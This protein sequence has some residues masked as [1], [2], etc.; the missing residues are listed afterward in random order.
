MS[1]RMQLQTRL[2]LL[3]ALAILCCAALSTPASA[4]AKQKDVVAACKRMGSGCTMFPGTNGGVG[5]CTKIVC[6]SC[7]KGKCVQ[8]RVSNSDGLQHRSAA[9]DTVGKLLSPGGT[10]AHGGNAALLKSETPLK[11]ATPGSSHLKTGVRH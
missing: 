8:T 9:G 1:N 10:M 7:T 6:F 4:A 2:M 3:P 5:G 11:T